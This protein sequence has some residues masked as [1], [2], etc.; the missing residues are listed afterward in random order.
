MQEPEHKSDYHTIDQML[1]MPLKDY[2]ED[3]NQA[4]EDIHIPWDRNTY[5]HENTIIKPPTK[6][7]VTSQLPV[8]LPTGG[9]DDEQTDFGHI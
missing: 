9:D 5:Y 8:V 7:T 4:V 2:Q 6:L 1:N 3:F